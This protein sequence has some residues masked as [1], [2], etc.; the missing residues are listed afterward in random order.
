M[1]LFLY[2]NTV[3]FH[4]LLPVLRKKLVA[5][6]SVKMSNSYKIARFN[7]LEERALNCYHV[8]QPKS[9]I[10]ARTD[11]LSQYCLSL[12]IRLWQV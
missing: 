5:G 4:M 2:Y 7:K 8:R 1:R 9:I 10:F 12:A 3:Y 6:Y 11:L